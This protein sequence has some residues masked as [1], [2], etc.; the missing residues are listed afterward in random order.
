MPYAPTK[1]GLKLYYEEAGD[2]DPILFAHEFAGDYRSWE[3]Q[4][5]F[6]SRR[7]RCITYSARG[8]PKSD[9]PEGENQYGELHARD[10]L[11]AILDHL[12]IDRA[13]VVG[14]SMGSYAA[15]RAGMEYPDRVKALVLAAGGSGSEPDR[16]EIFRS[17]VKQMADHF[18][19]HGSDEMARNHGEGPARIQLEIKDPR[20]FGDFMTWLAEHSASGSAHTMRNYQ[21]GRASLWTF[22]KELED[23]DIPTL[24]IVGDEDEACIR[25][26]LYLKRRIKRGSQSLRWAPW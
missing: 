25:P 11:I 22:Q 1:D 12:K 8:Y 2:G 26:G 13:V 15:V 5:R 3:A 7:H 20:G 14:L 18:A 19:K 9:V 23:M 21:G 4:M 10:D 6:F 24:I 16:V 17:E